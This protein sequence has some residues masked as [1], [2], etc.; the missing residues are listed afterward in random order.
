M[1][2]KN[3][4]TLV[5]NY[6]NQ[7]IK[8]IDFSSVQ[9][10]STD[11]ATRLSVAKRLINTFDN[12]QENTCGID[13][14]LCSLRNFMLFYKTELELK[15]LSIPIPNDYCI[16]KSISSDLYFAN[17]GLNYINPDF[18]DDIYSLKK[19]NI[20]MNEKY[21][22]ITDGFIYNLT[23]FTH[24]K[25]ISQKIAVYGALKTPK[26]YTSLI[27]L[28]TGG[29]KSLITQT[30]AYQEE[31][32]TI[33]VVPTI[34]LAIDQV[35]S[36]KINIKR[37]TVDEEIFY[38]SSGVD[39]APICDAIRKKKAKLLF[40]SPEAL[41]QNKVFIKEL[42]K[43][44]KSR[45]LKK[46]IIDEAH[47]VFD[48]G[49][50]FR[51]EYQYLDCWRKEKMRSNNNLKTI[52]LSAT[53]E[54]KSIDTLKLMF[55]DNDCWIEIRCDSLRHEPRYQLVNCCNQNMKNDK[56]IDL[57]RKLP[58]PIIVYTLNPYEAKKIQNNLR[59]IGLIQVG[60]FT[61]ETPNFERERLIK[62]WVNNE[63]DIMIATSA[64][65]VGVDKNDI[66]TVLHTYIPQ[67]PN[68][69]YQ[70]LGRGGRDGFASLSV[71]CITK[72]KDIANAQN[73]LSKRVMTTDK[74]C[75]RWD[76]MLNS[77]SSRYIN[78]FVFLDI[79]TRPNYDEDFDILEINEVNEAH[80]V[81][82]I[83]VLLFMRRYKYIQ[84]LDIVIK[85]EKRFFKVL[86]KNNLLL[87]DNLKKVDLIEK[88]HLSE[89]QY[90][91]RMFD[92]I[93]YCI[94]NYNTTC[95]W[96]KMFNDV[97]DKTDI[98]C[99]GCGIHKKPYSE[100]DE[101]FLKK[102]VSSPI[103]PITVNQLN[104]FNNSIEILIVNKFKSVD[105]EKLSKLDVSLI[106]DFAGQITEETIH[107]A[108]KSLLTIG[109]TELKTLKNKNKYYTSGVIVIIYSSNEI[110]VQDEYELVF[111]YLNNENNKL[112][113]FFTNDIYMN[114]YKKYVSEIINGPSISE[115]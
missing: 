18:L 109:R 10:E 69:Y 108:K 11:D 41:M 85:D 56:I 107:L 25:T 60:I 111:H 62:G 9:T 38:Y 33:V 80:I 67:N 91:R 87:S 45:Y 24:F 40:I 82:N 77:K 36:A 42:D 92:K 29:G 63:F 12:Y 32:L 19:T 15:N 54:K 98:Y 89:V 55:C 7:T 95:C 31:G 27:S 52:L 58:R 2:Y 113:H 57:I 5:E 104:Y 47:I 43:A 88:I 73:R 90:F 74:I 65:G 37:N 105:Y 106:V 78:G 103:T 53:Y 61:G 94:D 21:N 16:S 81:W 14:M 4:K 17:Y 22:L 76:S 44:N 102:V 35:R 23:G 46:L 50:S 75:A 96:S 6:L 86:I 34:S 64:F 30:L 110:C 93:I 39:I 79:S 100:E 83:Y 101:Y 3:I 28:P 8:E 59:K 97:Y 72:D 68:E 99:G 71:V 51:V 66:R 1:M 49:T 13:D 115:L 70:E 114:R 112:I 48:W 84:I 20:D 26:G